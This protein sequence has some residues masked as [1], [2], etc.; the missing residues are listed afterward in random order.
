MSTEHQS[1]FWSRFMAALFSL[2]AVL[3]VSVLLM[4]LVGWGDRPISIHMRMLLLPIF[5]L[6]I[7]I[8]SRFYRRYVAERQRN[9]LLSARPAEEVLAQDRPYIVYLRSFNDE[10][11]ILKRYRRAWPTEEE[12]IAAAFDAYG[13]L[14]AIRNPAEELPALGA[15]RLSA[16]GDT[17][18]EKVRNLVD[19]AAFVVI[20]LGNSPGVLWEL[21]LVIRRLP[22]SR[23]LLLSALTA[24]GHA[25]AAAMLEE[26]FDI[27]LPRHT[28][29]LSAITFD[30]DWRPAALFLR[31]WNLRSD[32]KWNLRGFWAT[33]LQ[34]ALQAAL[35]PFFRR[36]GFEA[37]LPPVGWKGIAKT[38]SVLSMLAILCWGF[39]FFPVSLILKPPGDGVTMSA[40]FLTLMILST[41]AGLVTGVLFVGQLY[42]TVKEIWFPE[43]YF[44]N[45][46]WAIR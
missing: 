8:G 32:L 34:A 29:K 11:H 5:V 37:E 46:W 35:V 22:P 10:Q 3:M 36:L 17:W 27:R 38:V 45:P 2:C 14:I 13:S 9:I 31:S 39:L 23:V 33:T 41:V 4:E 30:D 21:N 25:T 19:N 28:K 15:A 24:D 7:L 12:Q 40:G 26:H 16:S 42:W 43:H 1:Y 18:E 6:A 44:A 20:R